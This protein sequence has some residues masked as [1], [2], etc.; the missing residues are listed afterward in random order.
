[1][2]GSTHTQVDMTLIAVTLVPTRWANRTK[3]S[4]ADNGNTEFRT[5]RKEARRLFLYPI[6]R[7]RVQPGTTC[8]KS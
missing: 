8:F 7:W 6:L 3:N 1:L 4:A 5:I 2:L